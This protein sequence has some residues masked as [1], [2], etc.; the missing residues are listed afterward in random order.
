[1]ADPDSEIVQDWVEQIP[2][3]HRLFMR[4]PVGWLSQPER[5]LHPGIFREIQG[6]ISV[7][8]EKFSTPQQTRN[9]ARN[10][11][12][13]GVISLVTGKVRA[14]EGLSVEHEPL[15]SNR[16]HSGIHG[17]TIPGSLP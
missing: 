14:I 2:D 5:Q 6:A 1:M 11:S 13:N 16:S 8:W 4:V 12:Q 10:P 17:L 9:R 3:P 15:R 7:D